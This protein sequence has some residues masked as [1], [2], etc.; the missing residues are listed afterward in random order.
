MRKEVGIALLL[1]SVIGVG[2]ALLITT[3]TR[4]KDTP[5]VNG[6]TT[7][8]QQ[9]V[10]GSV[11]GF[12]LSSPALNQSISGTATI[13]GNT[14]ADAEYLLI[15]SGTTQSISKLNGPAFSVEIAPSP[16]PAPIEFIAIKKDS[17]VE[18]LKRTFIVT[19]TP[20]EEN[21]RGIYQ[22]TITDIDDQ[23]IQIRT[24]TGD[25]AQ[26]V[27]NDTT[28]YKSYLKTPK[29]LK[30]SDIAIGDYVSAVGVMTERGILNA[31]EML[32]LPP[33]VEATDNEA[34]AGV[35]T[36]VSRRQ[37]ILQTKDSNKT[38]EITSRA[39]RV[40]NADGTI[41]RGTSAL[42]KKDV[43]LIVTDSTFFVI[44]QS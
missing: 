16:G 29:D 25:V 34:D 31:K 28:I 7:S 36:E 1:G 26:A 12:S 19:S 44:S 15:K 21:A 32:I 37:I 38:Y 11:Q 30:L 27:I 39:I 8:Q 40:V 23:T 33:Q 14:P 22:G 17:S 10:T 4:T 42:L 41:A 6:D 18:R 13:V 2:I 24:Q 5:I 3:T 35:I 9:V 43:R 20:L